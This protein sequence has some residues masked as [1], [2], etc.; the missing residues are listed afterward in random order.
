[1][2]DANL[3][4]ALPPAPGEDAYRSLAFADSVATLPGGQ[5]YDLLGTPESAMR[6]LS[7]HE[8]RAPDVRLYEVCAARM[9]TLRDHVRVLFAAHID[10]AA[11]PEAAVTALNDALT[12]V[13]TAALLV[14]DATNGPRRVQAHPTDQ[15]VNHA[16]AVLAADAAQLLTGPDSGRLARCEAL[17]C[18]R[19]L[20]RT[21]GRR[22][23][24]ST[25]CGDRVRAARARQRKALHT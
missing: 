9:R 8:L 20:V 3:R 12:S 10:G 13:P 2:I 16:L 25:R 6:W 19:F 1:M 4:A 18:D 14:W 22:Q 15:A 11:P 7:S 23:W 24:C 17:P 21:H 5:W